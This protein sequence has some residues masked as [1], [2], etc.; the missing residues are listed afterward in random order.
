[1]KNIYISVSKETRKIDLPD[2]FISVDGE[3][4]QSNFVFKFKD[5]FVVGQARLEFKTNVRNYVPMERIENTYQIPVKSVITK[6]GKIWMQLVI[7]EPSND[8]E[9]TKDTEINPQKV[10][11]ELIDN[12]YIAVV[13]PVVED[14]GSYYENVN[15]PIFKSKEYYLTCE[16]SIN[17]VSEAPDGYI[18]WIERANAIL[19]QMDTIDIDIET[20]ERGS[21][22]VITRKDG[23]EKRAVV[24]GGGGTYDH[25]QLNNLDY[26]NSG[27]TGFQATINDLDTIRTGAS[28]GATAVQDNAY[29]HTDNNYT[30]PEKNKL[31]ELENYDD[32]EI[33]QDIEDIQDVIPTQATSEN[34]LADKDFVNSSIATNT[35]TFRGTYESESELPTTGI[36]NNDYAFVVVYDEVEPSE[37][38]QYDRYKWNGTQWVYEY[39]LNNSSFTAN[40]WAS[41][42]SGITSGDVSKLAGIEE[43]AEVNDIDTIK[44]Q[45]ITQSITDKTVNLD[46]PTRDDIDDI[47]NIKTNTTGYIDDAKEYRTFNKVIDGNSYQD[48]TTGKNKF[49]K[50]LFDTSKWLVTGTDEEFTIKPLASGT[51]SQDIPYDFSECYFKGTLDYTTLNGS[52]ALRDGTTSRAGIISVFDNT[53]GTLDVSTTSGVTNNMRIVMY[54]VNSEI[55][56][57]NCQLEQGSTYTDYEPYT[58]GQPSPS[59]DYPQEIE[60]IEDSIDI[61]VTGKNIANRS[62]IY[63]TYNLN[64]FANC[65]EITSKTLTLSF[66]TDVNLNNNSLYLKIDDIDAPTALVGN[67]TGSANQKTSYTF[68]LI[69]AN[70]DAIKNGTIAQFIVYKQDANFTKLE[71]VQLEK[72]STATS[73]EP[74]KSTTKTIDLDDEFVGKVGDVK[75]ELHID[76]YGNVNLLKKIGKVV[77]DGSQ[78]IAYQ[79]NV[80]IYIP[81]DIK[82]DSEYQRNIKVLSNYYKAETSRNR[83]EIHNNCIAKIVGANSQIG[84]RNDEYTSIVDFET[85]LSTHNT[86]VY[87]ELAEPYTVQLGNIGEINTY[88]GIN[89]IEVISNLDTTFSIEY[90]G[91][92][93]GGSGNVDDVKV[94]GTSVVT[95]KIANIDLTDYVKNTD[96]AGATAGVVRGSYSTGSNINLG[97]ISGIERT[98]NDYSGLSNQYI[99]SKGTL[100]NVITGKNLL[101]SNDVKNNVTSTDTDKPL[102]ANMGKELNDRIQNLASIGKYLAMW[103]S[104]TGLPTT[105][106]VT[107]P[108]TYT[109]G[110][111]YVISKIGETNYMPNGATYSGTASTTEYTGTDE[112]NIGDF[113]YYDGTVWSLMKNTGKTVAFANIAGSPMDN[114]NLASALNNKLNTSKVTDTTSTT[115]GDVYDVTYINSM[116]GDIETLLE[117]LL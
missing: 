68:T 112:L 16:E 15:I 19:N 100:E 113:F 81:T 17:A 8:Y 64:I 41:I 74:Y 28:L 66:I 40:Q 101:S 31:A 91:E 35:A 20:T 93:S 2:N 89:N 86:E 103:D 26:A 50:A 56:F 25:R 11:Y 105:N 57:K 62:D 43:G 37:V 34:Q 85:W 23:E 52:V 111:Y 22:V 70:Y 44:V 106:P 49:G 30:T 110:D 7:T 79:N 95:N 108:Y 42:N 46:V 47:V 29:T 78:T 13:N 9:L 117:A 36:T 104:T 71:Q 69:D 87:Y 60:V 55:T 4:L 102:S 82:Q 98:F 39:T 96:Y 27:H 63:S 94:D 84:I 1:M 72:G 59:P 38:K 97:Y 48:S 83:D 92:V 32:T 88:K 61:K 33:R 75:D 6:A 114:S 73:Y 107:M 24:S 14:I 51:T 90:A 115:S 65:N 67:V 80:F 3:N 21:E 77:L 54:N 45:G 116:I 5:E 109:T 10:Y 99:I 12:K 18:L 58:G 76:K 53:S